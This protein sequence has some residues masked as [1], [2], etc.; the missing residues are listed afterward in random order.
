M[1]KLNKNKKMKN[2]EINNIKKENED[3]LLSKRLEDYKEI[4]LKSNYFDSEYLI[5]LENSKK[6]IEEIINDRNANKTDSLNIKTLNTGREINSLTLI[7]SD[8]KKYIVTSSYCYI[9]L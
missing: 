5:N 1:K 6:N 8:K 2:K 7:Q 3:E 9:N 4:N